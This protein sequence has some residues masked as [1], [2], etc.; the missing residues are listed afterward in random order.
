MTKE[1]RDE[2]LGYIAQEFISPLFWEGKE[3]TA[4]EI[5]LEWSGNKFNKL[6]VFVSQFVTEEEQ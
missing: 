4:G 1:Q 3:K 6:C 2:I 5:W